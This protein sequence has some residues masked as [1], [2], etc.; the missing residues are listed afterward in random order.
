MMYTLR[1][2]YLSFYLYADD[3]NIYIHFKI[4]DLSDGITKLKNDIGANAAQ[5]ITM[6]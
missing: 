5:L 2:V 6:E 1:W 3:L 4:L